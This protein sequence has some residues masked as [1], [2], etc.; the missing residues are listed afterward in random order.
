M[1]LEASP[2]G[3]GLRA[4]K[5]HRK[6]PKAV[7]HCLAAHLHL[8][9]HPPSPSPPHLPVLAPR[10]AYAPTSCC[11]ARVTPQTAASL[12]LLAAPWASF[13]RTPSTGSLCTQT[14]SGGLQPVVHVWCMVLPVGHAGDASMLVCVCACMLATSPCLYVCL[15][16]LPMATR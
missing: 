6:A 7:P 5:C 8:P 4:R 12:S 9:V 3:G 13:C 1:L 14:H 11:S 10:C 2:P 16:A 15:R